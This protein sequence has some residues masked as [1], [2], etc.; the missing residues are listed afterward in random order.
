M[1]PI[2]NDGGS[3]TITSPLATLSGVQNK[4]RSDQPFDNVVVRIRSDQGIYTGQFVNWTY[5]RPDFNVS[6]EPYP[7]S[8]YACFF[9]DGADTV[10]FK[11]I[12]SSADATNLHFRMLSVRGYTRGAIWFTGD[13]GLATGFNSYNS[14]TNCIF[15]DIGNALYPDK[16]MCYGVLDLV[17]SRYNAIEGCTFMNCANANTQ[18]FPQVVTEATSSTLLPLV[19][20]YLAHR[21]VGNLVTGCTFRSI[22][23]D[24]IRIRDRSNDNVICYNY[25]EQVGWN[26]VCSMWYCHPQYGSCGYFECPSWNN[27]FYDNTIRG[28][29]LCGFSMVFKDLRPEDNNAIGCQYNPTWTRINLYGNTSDSC[30][31]NNGNTNKRPQKG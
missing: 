18:P 24:G 22:K 20:V 15:H 14:I 19:T 28:N 7:D 8:L 13:I 4:L 31:S 11:L 9:G 3:G 26:A 25:F 16:R 6:F 27:W 1:S 17:N 10:F 12:S 21:S 2:G 30:T 5:H 23:G 29:W